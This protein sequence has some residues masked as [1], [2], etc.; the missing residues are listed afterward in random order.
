MS[1]K[2]QTGKKSRKALTSELFLVTDMVRSREVKPHNAGSHLAG[3]A[4]V[5]V[6]LKR[7][8]NLLGVSHPAHLQITPEACLLV[9]VDSG[10]VQ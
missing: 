5:S 2:G 6:P 1:Q 3:G 8:K 7:R 10:P 9:G 4:T